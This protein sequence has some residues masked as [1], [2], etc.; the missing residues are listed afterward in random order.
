MERQDRSR[1]DHPGQSNTGQVWFAWVGISKM[2]KS[3]I[4]KLPSPPSAPG[5]PAGIKSVKLRPI[6]SKR[7]NRNVGEGP[8]VHIINT[9]AMRCPRPTPGKKCLDKTGPAKTIPARF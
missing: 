3:K 7:G 2:Q 4:P 8:D 9:I 6:R 1:Q 5:R